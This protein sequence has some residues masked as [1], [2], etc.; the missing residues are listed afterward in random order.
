MTSS[1]GSEGQVG[2]LVTPAVAAGRRLL[3]ARGAIILG[4]HDVSAPGTPASGLTVGADDLDRHLRL[5]RL[6]GFTPVHLEVILDRLSAGESVDDL[7]AITFDD[8]LLGVHR[9]GLPTL[10]RHGVPATVF[11]VTEH[12][13]VDPPWWP[14][15]ART[16]TADELADLVTAGHHIGSHTCYH[17]SLVELDG[18]ALG[19]DLAGSHQRIMDLTGR[20]PSSL[21]YPS[22]HHNAVVRRAARECGYRA[23]LTF[24]NGRAEVGVDSFRLPRLTMGAHHSTPR[25]AYHVGRPARSW[26]DHQL[27]QVGR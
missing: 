1:E 16:L 8:A 3:R 7:V 14:G 24:L 6:W 15:M 18:R 10:D 25:L 19:D 22:G 2:R 17:R 23:G 9:W 5:L 27:D 11:V 26:P 4:Y 20:P 21:A 13:G 12:L